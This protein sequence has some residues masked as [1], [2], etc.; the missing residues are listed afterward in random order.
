M[1]KTLRQIAS[2]GIDT[3][4][5]PEA[6]DSLRVREERQASIRAVLGR[7]LCIRPVR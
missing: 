5:A 3:E 6:D 1:L 4:P 7:V 2:I